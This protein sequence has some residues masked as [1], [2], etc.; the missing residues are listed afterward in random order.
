MNSEHLA[1]M[2][3]DEWR[4]YVTGLLEGVRDDITELKA[5]Q[6][7]LASSVDGLKIKAA[8]SSGMI[9]VVVSV[10]VTLMGIIIKQLL[11]K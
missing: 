6:S 9:A 2:S 11:G 1:R 10:V 4:G 8:R 5:A 3:D 7:R